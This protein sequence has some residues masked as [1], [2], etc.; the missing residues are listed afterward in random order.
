MQNRQGF[1]KN[2][3]KQ[4]NVV[5]LHANALI[6]YKS[7]DQNKANDNSK[8]VHLLR[9]AD[10][11]KSNDCQLC[12]WI[13]VKSNSS[14]FALFVFEF[15]FSIVIMCSWLL[16]FRLIIDPYALIMYLNV[17]W[18]VNG[19]K[20]M[21]KENKL[22][23]KITNFA[24]WIWHKNAQFL[25]ANCMPLE[26]NTH[27]FHHKKNTCPRAATHHRQHLHTNALPHQ[28]RRGKLKQFTQISSNIIIRRL[29]AKQINSN[30]GLKHIIH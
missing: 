21:K 23:W 16:I 7:A 10:R 25:H 8:S 29:I 9:V 27:H 6:F 18:Q 14:R 1:M 19:Q 17:L 30:C 28:M 11:S 3:L 5:N 24:I 4:A 12:Q 20:K 15:Y 22:A 13:L 26:T 2:E